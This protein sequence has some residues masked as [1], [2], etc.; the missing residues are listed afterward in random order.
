MPA[1]QFF[2][3]NRPD[4]IPQLQARWLSQDETVFFLVM[5]IYASCAS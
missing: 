5:D 1:E 3:R 4:E 2:L